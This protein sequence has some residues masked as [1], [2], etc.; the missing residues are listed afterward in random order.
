MGDALEIRS[1]LQA[2]E[3]V[4]TAGADGLSD[5]STVRVVRDI[6]PYTGE[7]ERG[8]G[9]ARSNA[10]QDSPQARLGE[11]GSGFLDL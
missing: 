5:G 1:G 9:L 10:D 4:V 2:G 6:N 11:F 7:K 8:G 3:E